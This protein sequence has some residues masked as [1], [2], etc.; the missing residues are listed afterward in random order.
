MRDLYGWF[1]LR[2]MTKGNSPD[3]HNRF[4][5]MT[6]L[7]IAMNF[8]RIP[9]TAFSIGLTGLESLGRDLIVKS[10]SSEISDERTVMTTTA[11]P[12]LD[13]LDPKSPWLIQDR[14]ESTWDVT[15][16]L[17]GSRLFAFKRSREGLSGVD[18]RTEQDF[19]YE[20]QEWFPFV[21]TSQ[22][23]KNLLSCAKEL[24]LEF[25]RF[26]FMSD[27][28]DLTSLIFLEVN[29]NGQWMFLDIENRY[30]LLEAV[31]DWLRS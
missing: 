26:D 16:F 4:A 11:I 17:C 6:V 27:R 31:T 1:L 13:A 2:G 18:W 3:Y 28:D 7:G 9:E 25:A 21:L 10:Q 22:N 24:D 30:G 19:N 5:K 8:F 20:N 29:A 12:S 23:S 15:V 14:V